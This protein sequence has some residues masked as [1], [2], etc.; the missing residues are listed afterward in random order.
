MASF[1]TKHRRAVVKRQN[2]IV[3]LNLVS[4][5]DFFTILLVFL[6]ANS[7]ETEVLT[8]NSVIKLPESS[9]HQRP[10]DRMVISVSNDQIVV[11]SRRVAD[12]SQMKP[13]QT[14]MIAGLERELRD[15]AKRRG[16]VPAKGF[17]VTV[18]G[19]RE[20]P[21]WLMKRIMMTCQATDF[22]NVSLAVNRVKAEQPEGAVADANATGV[23]LQPGGAS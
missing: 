14:G 22:A 19:D 4:L 23:T 7:S 16:E 6:L 13:T 10:E 21:Y 5:T 9:S 2:G 1:R 3:T 18:M 17:D 12:V 20:I 8:M 15:E 11:N